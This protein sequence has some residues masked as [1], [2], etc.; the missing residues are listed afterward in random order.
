MT[1]NPLL[2]YQSQ[3]KEIGDC[4]YVVEPLGFISAR[5]TFVRLSNLLGPSLERLAASSK[6]VTEGEAGALG[7]FVS[8]LGGLLKEL[9]DSDPDALQAVFAPKTVVHLP[10]GKEPQLSKVIDSHFA[11]KRFGHYFIWLAFCIEV[12]YADFFS[13]AL[14]MAKAAMEKAAAKKASDAA[15]KPPQESSSDQSIPDGGMNG[16]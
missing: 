10:D 9:E 12:N 4:S 8:L 14:A 5:K 7:A 15:K 13:E 1:P 3:T 6:T 16:D 11:G 2:Q